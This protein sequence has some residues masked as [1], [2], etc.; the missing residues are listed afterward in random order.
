MKVIFEKSDLAAALNIVSKAVAQRSVTTILECVLITATDGCIRLTASNNELGIETLSDG[1]IEE[2]GTVALN[3]RLFSDLIRKFPDSE[4]E[5]E[6]NEKNVATISCEASQFRLLGQPGE[7][8]PDLAQ[9]DPSDAIEISEFALKEAIR[10]TIFSVAEQENNQILTGELFEVNDNE[11]KVVALDGHRIAIRRILLNDSYGKK[12]VIV[13]GKTLTEL[14]KILEGN[15]DEIVQIVFSRNHLVFRFGE[16]MVVTSLI[17]G[18]FFDVSR[19]IYN[20]FETKVVVN[21]KQLQSCVD[22]ACLLTGTAD[23]K[24]IIMGIHDEDI[25]IS[26]STYVGSMNEVLWIEKEG[27]NMEI[28]FNPKYLLDVLRVIDDEDITMYLINQKY[29]CV[30]KDADETYLYLVLPV[31]ISA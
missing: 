23:K 4:I 30:I 20:D 16:T 8:F 24:P 12:K 25:V 10:Q 7:E 17:E 6:V 19:M 9:I 2:E 28:G 3:A 31:N 21:K 5:L 1:T 15:A 11:L 22:R 27:K 14:S 26:T 29:P 13:P 18:N